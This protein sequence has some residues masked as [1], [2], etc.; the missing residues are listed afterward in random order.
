MYTS[1]HAD[2]GGTGLFMDIIGHLL[3]C[4][5]TFPSTYVSSIQGTIVDLVDDVEVPFAL[6]FGL[7]SCGSTAAKLSVGYKHFRFQ[8]WD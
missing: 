4:I 3:P 6:P 5:P 7:A 2:G 8:L 1:R